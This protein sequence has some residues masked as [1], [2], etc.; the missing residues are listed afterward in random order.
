MP[1]LSALAKLPLICQTS[2]PATP[3]TTR[4]TIANSEINLRERTP[5]PLVL[6]AM[7]TRLH[8][9]RGAHQ[10]CPKRARLANRVSVPPQDLSRAG[11]PLND[12]EV[13]RH[14]VRGGTCIWPFA[15]AL[16]TTISV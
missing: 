2:N 6:S 4:P 12:G 13:G 3:A 10:W 16:P 9:L 8:L 15:G 11:R 1:S 7:K 5:P 14:A